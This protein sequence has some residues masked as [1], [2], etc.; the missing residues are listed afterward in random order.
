MKHEQRHYENQPS[1]ERM[2]PAR[3]VPRRFRP[4][5]V[6]KGK[7]QRRAIVAAYRAPKVVPA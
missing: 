5:G 1:R 6:R 2:R 4:E 3:G 7:G